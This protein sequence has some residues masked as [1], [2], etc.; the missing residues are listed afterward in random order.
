MGFETERE[1]KRIREERLPYW[2]SQIQG[3][4]G[5]GVSLRVDVEG[6]PPEEK[7]IQDFD[8]WG[9]ATLRNVFS[10]IAREKDFKDYVVEKVKVVHV[11]NDENL[12]KAKYEYD[13]ASLTLKITTTSKDEKWVNHANLLQFLK[14][15]L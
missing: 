12:G 11:A 15:T 9:L 7:K 14:T 13:A 1:K 8:F 10:S 5:G 6:L 3:K 4:L 2:Q